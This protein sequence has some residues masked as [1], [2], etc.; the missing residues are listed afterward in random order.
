ML[1]NFATDSSSNLTGVLVLSRQFQTCLE[2]ASGFLLARH[3][4]VYLTGAALQ[5]RLLSLPANIRTEWK[6]MAWAYALAYLAVGD[7]NKTFCK[8]STCGQCYKTFYGHKL[9]LFIKS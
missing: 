9:R 8:I 7:K 1:K 4:A 6:S 2:L 3:A 5:G